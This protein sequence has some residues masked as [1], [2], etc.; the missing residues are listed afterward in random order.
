MGRPPQAP[1]SGGGKED[2]GRRYWNVPKPLGYAAAIDGFGSVAA[3]LLAGFTIALIGITVPLSSDS[4]V[5]NPGTALAFLAVS[6]LSL[7]ASVQCS[8]WAR[9]Y[10]VKPSEILDWWPDSHADAG[11]DRLAAR[12]RLQDLRLTQWRYSKI[13]ATWLSRARLSYHVGILALLLGVLIILVPKHWTPSRVAGC[14]VLGIG[15]IAE[16]LWV[17]APTRRSW[18][19]VK[20]VFPE[21]IDI[22]I[23]PPAYEG[24]H[25]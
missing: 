17:V 21:P 2:E 8:M 22:A 7:L 4:P 12:S 5:R 18:P 25:P 19:L 20:R 15:F 10:V 3:P 11:L 23:T 6:A 13:S 14:I 1:T 24:P 9:Q 16:V